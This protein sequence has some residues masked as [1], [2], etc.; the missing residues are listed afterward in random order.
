[1]NRKPNSQDLVNLQANAIASA[2]EEAQNAQDAVI[3]S[4]LRRI[5]KKL[6]VHS[7][8]IGASLS[9]AQRAAVASE[10]L[11]E[12]ENEPEEEEGPVTVRYA[13]DGKLESISCKGGTKRVVWAGEKA[14]SVN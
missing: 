14:I 9:F 12:M 4:E 13:K 5:E 7:D 8:G 6:D 10:K 2:Y 3:V 1:M 11:L